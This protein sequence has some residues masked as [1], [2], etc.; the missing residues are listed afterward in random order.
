M[1]S[2]DTGGISAEYAR[3]IAHVKLNCLAEKRRKT[4]A[5]RKSQIELRAGAVNA[6]CRTTIHAGGAQRRGLD[7]AEHSAKMES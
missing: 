1:V 3:A 4:W 5:S 2:Y 6:R 7:G